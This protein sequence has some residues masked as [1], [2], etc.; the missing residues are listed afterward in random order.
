MNLVSEMHIGE[1]VYII[2]HSQCDAA[3]ES[4]ESKLARIIFREIEHSFKHPDE[5][6]QLN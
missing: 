1:T 4:V 6:H 5:K 3:K 2:E